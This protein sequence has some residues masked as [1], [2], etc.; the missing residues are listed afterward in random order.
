[1][2]ILI[3]PDSFKGTLSAGEVCRVMA[4][5]LR[6]R[7][8]GVAVTEIPIADGGEGTAQAYLHIFGGERRTV[9]AHSPLGRMIEAAYALLPDGTAVIETAAASGI[10]IEP[11]YDAMRAST[12]G[13]GELIKD[14]LDRGCKKILLG[15]GGS[16]TTDGGTGCAR[17]LGARFFDESGND[18]P[19]GGVGLSA[20]KRADFSALDP[21]LQKITL[22]VLCDVTNPLFGKNGAA[23]VYARQKG[24]DDEQIRLLDRGLQTLAAVCAPLLG[25]N[26][27][28]FPGAG[29]AGGLGYCAR[30]MLGGTLRRGIDCILDAADFSALAQR[31]DLVITGEGKM[32]AQSL[33]GKAPFGVAL[34]SGSA[35]V[36]AVVGRLDAAMEDVR[37]AGIAAVFETDPDHRPFETIRLTA[38]EDLIR[39]VNKIKLEVFL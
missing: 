13:T 17:A 4:D 16:A 6:L 1:M 39:T 26:Q 3:A 36:I 9:C 35:P 12:F 2:N 31:A 33:M 8:P 23:Y 32:D 20:L 14:A 25:E 29:A 37:R 10:T 38:K 19:D 18:I 24:A 30:A 34:R 11:V 27:A 22:T 21:R 5:T 7:Y 28:T 15:L